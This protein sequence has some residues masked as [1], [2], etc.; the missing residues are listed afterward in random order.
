MK[1]SKT[2]RCVAVR[3]SAIALVVAS[4]V[5][6]FGQE[7]QTTPAT[8]A[9][10]V[11]LSLIVVDKSNQS[12]DDVKKD[13][14]RLLE[15][16]LPQT[17]A[18][19]AKAESAVDYGIAIDTSGSFKTLL[20]VVLKAVDLLIKN[21]RD[22]DEC[23]IERFVS[24]DKVERVQDFTSDKA[25]LRATLSKLYI[26]GGQSAV[27]DAI[28]LAVQYIAQRPKN[29]QRRR[30]LVV[31]TDGED[32][33]SYYT[34]EHLLKLLRAADVQVF[35]IGLVSELDKTERLTRP[36]IRQKAR[37]FLKAIARESGGR[38]FFPEKNIEISNALGEINHDL[39]IQYD[40]S[41]QSTDP[42]TEN[43]HPVRFE[44]IESPSRKDV[45][46]IT[47]P[48]YYLKPPEIGEKEKQK[49]PKTKKP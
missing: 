40:I 20:P 32:R 27:I 11:N 12:L 13:E 31:F 3:A 36:S 33:A 4:A 30:A 6:S 25:N 29:P 34:L 41:Y 39:H 47:R 14:L 48:G 37:D 16:K 28:Y 22:D 45:T 42:S 2:S 8:S 38:V 26:E 1:R 9:R 46:T 24:S 44:I 23:F 21:Q 49:E 5:M 15:N 10:T 7:P 18:T 19:F 43:F 35:V 17:I